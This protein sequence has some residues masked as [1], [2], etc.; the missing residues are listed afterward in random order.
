MQ[1]YFKILAAI[2]FTL[3]LLLILFQQK[4]S[5]LVIIKI[6]SPRILCLVTTSPSNH[7]TK[8]IAVSETWG[9]RCDTLLFV[10]SQPE[11]GLPIIDVKCEKEDHDHLWCKNRKGI[12]EAHKRF[13]DGYDWFLK[14]DDDTYVVVENL[15]HLVWLSLQLP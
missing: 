3:C 2:V 13:K 4:Y 12:E 14:A 5:S 11:K 7:K 1:K 8:A 6:K 10:S 9:Q 15:R